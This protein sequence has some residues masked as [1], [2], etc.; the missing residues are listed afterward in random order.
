MGQKRAVRVI[1]RS[2]V[3]FT[4]QRQADLELATAV[5][6]QS[7]W[8]GR[9]ERQDL[10]RRRRLLNRLDHEQATKIKMWFRKHHN[11][12]RVLHSRLRLMSHLQYGVLCLPLAVRRMDWRGRSGWQRLALSDYVL[13][14]DP[15]ALELVWSRRAKRSQLAVAPRPDHAKAEAAHRRLKSPRRARCRS[16]PG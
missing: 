2:W 12:E 11:S 4:K 5:L 7:A 9:K 15:T 8:R 14:L 16:P 1:E 13:T 6:F 3:R 10:D